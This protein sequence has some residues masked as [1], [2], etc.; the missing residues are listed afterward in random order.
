VAREPKAG[1]Y[2]EVPISLK[3][4]FKTLYKG[5]SAMRKLT[6]AAIQFAIK[7]HPNNQ[8]KEVEMKEDIRR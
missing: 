1:W 6:I 2:V 4:E 7:N 8:P 5:R 3:N